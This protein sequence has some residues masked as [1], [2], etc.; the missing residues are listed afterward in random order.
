MIPSSCAGQV[1]SSLVVILFELVVQ[2]IL[3]VF[4]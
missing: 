2:V 4:Y 3:L 1:V